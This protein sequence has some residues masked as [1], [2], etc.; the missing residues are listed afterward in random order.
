MQHPKLFK[1]LK[2]EQSEEFMRKRTCEFFYDK[3]VLNMRLQ[4]IEKDGRR[5]SAYF[6]VKT[7]EDISKAV[8]TF[9]EE[10]V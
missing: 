5:M 8:D 2:L 4:G 1:W 6:E 10:L 3:N 7:S 9:N